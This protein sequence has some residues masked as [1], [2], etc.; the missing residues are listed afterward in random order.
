[1]QDYVLGS[2]TSESDSPSGGQHIPRLWQPKIHDHV[3]KGPAPELHKSISRSHTPLFKTYSILPLHLLHPISLF[4]SVLEQNCVLSSQ[5]LMFNTNFPSIFRNMNLCY[6]TDKTICVS[7][8]KQF[9]KNTK[10]RSRTQHCNGHQ[11]SGSNTVNSGRVWTLQ[12]Y[13]NTPQPLVEAYVFYRRSVRQETMEWRQRKKTASSH[14]IYSQPT[15]RSS[16][17]TENAG[18]LRTPVWLTVLTWIRR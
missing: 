8:S 10:F 11:F 15:G 4:S 13:P 6:S 18:V 1:M 9:S 2:F 16:H 14:A 12:Y 3:H 7:K 5:Y 17:K